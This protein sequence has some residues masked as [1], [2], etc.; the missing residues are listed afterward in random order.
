MFINC[1]HLNLLNNTTYSKILK[2]CLKLI[3][4]NQYYD[5]INMIIVIDISKKQNKLIRLN[6]FTI[7]NLLI[8]KSNF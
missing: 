1:S 3:I 8:N 7:Y 4:S 2:K 6:K 5:A